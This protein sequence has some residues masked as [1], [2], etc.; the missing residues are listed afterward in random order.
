VVREN[1]RRQQA[2]QQRQE[3]DAHASSLPDGERQ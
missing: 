2:H 3:Q 1:R